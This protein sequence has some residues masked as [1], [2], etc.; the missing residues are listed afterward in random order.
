LCVVDGPKKLV[1]AQEVVW[2]K[3]R[4]NGEFRIIIISI[5]KIFWWSGSISSNL[6][7]F[8]FPRFWLHICYRLFVTS[9]LQFSP[10]R[11]ARSYSKGYV[12]LWPFSQVKITLFGENARAS[13]WECYLS[14]CW[15]CKIGVKKHVRSHG[16]VEF[17]VLL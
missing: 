15:H 10:V 17:S 14:C 16:R 3:S 5:R 9:I 8:V 12:M 6:I 2:E 7:D 4:R 11:L 13:S 1:M